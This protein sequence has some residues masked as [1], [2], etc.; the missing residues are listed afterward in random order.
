[1]SEQLQQVINQ[2]RQRQLLLKLSTTCDDNLQIIATQASNSKKIVAK[3][4]MSCDKITIL[5]AGDEQSSYQ[6][7]AHCI[8]MTSP[9]IKLQAQNIQYDVTQKINFRC[10]NSYVNL[11][12]AIVFSAQ[13]LKL[14][15]QNN[16]CCTVQ[17]TINFNG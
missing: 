14:K 11:N 6:Q 12:E 3:I 10:G 9:Q 8:Q 1:M 5:A 15:A 7:T 17:N 13:N 4:L 16:L 2:L